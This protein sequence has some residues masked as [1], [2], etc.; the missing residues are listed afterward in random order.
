MK[1]LDIS[2][3]E[4]IHNFNFSFVPFAEPTYSDLLRKVQEIKNDN[5]ITRDEAKEKVKILTIFILYTTAHF[6]GRSVHMF[7]EQWKYEN[8]YGQN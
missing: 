5:N 8:T 2:L 6:I 4:I 1:L 7:L 3:R